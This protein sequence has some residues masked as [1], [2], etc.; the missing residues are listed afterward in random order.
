MFKNIINEPACANNYQPTRTNDEQFSYKNM[1]VLWSQNESKNQYDTRLCSTNFSS[2]NSI[3]LSE[4]FGTHNQMFS[5]L[6]V[7]LIDISKTIF[8]F[9]LYEKLR[10]RILYMFDNVINVWLSQ[11]PDKAFGR[12]IYGHILSQMLGQ[13]L[14]FLNPSI[15]FIKLMSLLSPSCPT[16]MPNNV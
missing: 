3:I 6:N 13:R 9:T 14:A 12:N 5:S 1:L 16:C 7:T 8:L 15:I 11:F 10:I 4:Q 2:G